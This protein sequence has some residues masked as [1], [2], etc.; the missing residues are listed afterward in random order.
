[1]PALSIQPTFPIFTDIDGQ[2]L[3]SGYIWIGTTNLNPI[4]NPI[5]AYWDAALTLAAVQ[6]IRTIGGYPVNSGTPARL[7]VNSDYSIQVQNRNGSVVY[8]APA[9]TERLSGVVIEIDAT[10]VSFIQA[11]TGA[12]TR[13]AQ[14]KMRDVVSVKDFGAVGDGVTDDTAAI[15]NA[16]TY[17]INNGYKAVYIPAGVFVVSSTINLGRL[18]LY[19][20][21]DGSRIKPTISDGSA[22]L[23]FA[24]GTNLFSL[25]SFRIDSD[26]NTANFESGAIN[27][28]NCIGI[29][30]ISSGGTYSARYVM[31]DVIVR[32][33][34]TGY[35]INGFVGTLDNVWGLYCET[36]LTATDWNSTRAHLR[37]EQCRTDMVLT[38]SNGIHF[39]QYLSEG[40]IL[41]SGLATS[42][43]DN[44]DGIVFNAVYLEQVRNAPFITFGAT[45][46]CKNISI[47]TLSVG[48][49]DN[50]SKNNEI[51]VLAF[52]KVDGLYI[53]GYYSTG[54]NSKRYSSTTNTKNIVDVTTASSV[55]NFPNDNSKN[56]SVVRNYFPNSNFDLWLRGY[57][58]V[59]VL[60]GTASQETSIVRRGQNALKFQ[61]TA[62][63]VNGYVAFIFNDSYLALKLRSKT[64]S[65][66]AWVWVPNI[67]E[68]S[69]AN[70]STMAG[71]AVALFTDGT[72]GTTVTSTTNSINRNA[73]NLL[74][75]SYTVPSDATRLDAS[76]FVYGQNGS[77]T[78]NEYVVVDSMYLVEGT[79]QDTSVL[80]GFVADSDINQCANFGGRMVMRSDS[81][82]SDPDMTFE[83]GDT[84]W[85]FTVAAGGSPG[86]VCTTGGVGGVAVFKAM[87]NVAV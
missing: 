23:S 41:Q 46:E 13:T 1:M 28:Q 7:Y 50:A 53:G 58:A 19:G 54:T 18:C 2:P 67:S 74:K 72:G 17:A 15:Q 30:I 85:K 42:T 6:P 27:A 49:A 33:C 63:Q 26:L 36:G 60:R 70:R 24:A 81:A 76:I 83:V 69:P 43:V 61:I 12:V 32:G 39:D 62:A 75:V 64:I 68:F 20:D 37:F 55:G 47:G 87:A 79:G 86:W 66:Y 52:D 84:V 10:D 9:A 38:A 57:P 51:Y 29:K 65:L 40:A 31:R 35:D 22:V 25:Y 21:G 45:T 3:E 11:G 5:T 4:T 73:W 48:I 80:N 56:L 71:T 82:P 34:K 44:C 14:A 77:A 8:S 16:A 78:G 59:T